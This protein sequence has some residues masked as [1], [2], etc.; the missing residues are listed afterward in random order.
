MLYH[1][2]SKYYVGDEF[3]TSDPS[4]SFGTL[5]YDLCYMTN[6]KVTTFMVHG[7]TCAHICTHSIAKEQLERT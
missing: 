6:H 2:W 3:C 5:V 4:I 7:H 1:L